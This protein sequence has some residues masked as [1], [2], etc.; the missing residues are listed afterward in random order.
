[1]LLSGHDSL[2]LLNQNGNNLPGDEKHFISKGRKQNFYCN[3]LWFQFTSMLCYALKIRL[4]IT[5]DIQHYLFTYITYWMALASR[6]SAP[7]DPSLILFSSPLVARVGATTE[8]CGLHLANMGP[9]SFHLSTQF[10]A[11]TS[12]HSTSSEIIISS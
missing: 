2:L 11:L 3:F 8:G 5:P 10:H 7:E 4:Q 1:M 9:S 6:A 12:Q